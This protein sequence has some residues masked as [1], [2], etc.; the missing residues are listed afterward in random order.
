MA[1]WIFLIPANPACH[2]ELRWTLTIAFECRNRILTIQL[3]TGDPRD[4]VP[5]V[6][7]G[8]ARLIRFNP[9]NCE[10]S[11][12]VINRPSSVRAALKRTQLDAYS[13]RSGLSQCQ[14]RS[15]L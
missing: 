12:S 5:R 9:S 1:R 10:L 11:G 4:I 6:V 7:D 15:A 2:I 13:A 14:M 8:I 3:D